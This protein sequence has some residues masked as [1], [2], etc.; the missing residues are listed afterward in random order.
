[1][2]KILII[3]ASLAFVAWG[4]SKSDDDNYNTS[5]KPGEGTEVNDSTGNSGSDISSQLTPGERREAGL[6]G[7][8]LR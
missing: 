7:A 1:M 6:A 3:I 4:C 8:Q 5:G 2:K